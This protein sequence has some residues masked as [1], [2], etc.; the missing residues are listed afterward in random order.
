MPIKHLRFNMNTS[1][2][3]F[4]FSTFFQ[5]L[6]F[7]DRI[8]SRH[9]PIQ[10]DY[11]GKTVDSIAEERVE[12]KWKGIDKEDKVIINI[13]SD[14]GVN[15]PSSAAFFAFSSTHHLSDCF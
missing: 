1:Y 10:P 15:F 5:L 6:V 12:V 8:F 11:I 2:K 13:A 3:L 4:N 14:L 9:L 7:I